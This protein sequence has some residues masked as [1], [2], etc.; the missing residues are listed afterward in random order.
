[1]NLLTPTTMGEFRRMIATADDLAGAHVLWI[2]TCGEVHLSTDEPHRHDDNGQPAQSRQADVR[3]RFAPFEAGAG[4]VGPLAAHDDRLIGNMYFS[5]LHHW[6][7]AGGAPPGALDAELDDL[8]Q[9]SGWKMATNTGLGSPVPNTAVR[10]RQCG[11]R[12]C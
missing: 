6:L 8:E 9:P 10:R 12:V 4:M 7:Q 5:V 11:A 3:L 2:D 1:M